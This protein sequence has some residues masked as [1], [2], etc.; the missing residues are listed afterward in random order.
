MWM[1]VIATAVACAR[2]RLSLGQVRTLKQ[3]ERLSADG[4]EVGMDEGNNKPSGID[5]GRAGSLTRLDPSPLPQRLAFL[6]VCYSLV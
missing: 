5:Q 6:L 2:K 4:R 1:K 3:E